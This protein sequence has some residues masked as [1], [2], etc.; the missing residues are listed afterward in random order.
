MAE[1]A[2]DSNGMLMDE[3]DLKVRY[4]HERSW[5][6]GGKLVIF[7]LIALGVCLIIIGV[8]LLALAHFANRECSG[9]GPEVPTTGQPTQQIPKRC[10]F[11]VEAQRV[12]L[13]DCSGKGPEVPTTGQPTQQIPKRCEFSVEAQR[14]GLDEF[15]KKVKSTYF[16]LHPFSIPFHPDINTDLLAGSETI[17]RDYEA[18]DPTPSVIKNRTDVSWALL[19][20]ITRKTEHVK[21]NALLPRERKSLAQVKHYLQHTFGQP[22][23]VN[24][25]AGDWMMGPNLFCWQPICYHGYDFYNAIIHHR[26]TNEADVKLIRSK[27]A[28]H[29]RGILQYIDNMKMG[30]R[31]GMIRSREECVAGTD[32]LKRKYLNVSL[33]NET[34]KEFIDM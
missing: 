9:K 18:Y 15:L 24:Y 11:S 17:K 26:P 27:L 6:S 10:E 20:E 5:L 21:M 7:G 13:D 31:K 16:Q 14:V 12:G 30:V 3:V 8:I 29:Q 4:Q 22:Y 32:S 25:Y 2:E 34:G 23:D 28:T 19:E 1:K 33:Y